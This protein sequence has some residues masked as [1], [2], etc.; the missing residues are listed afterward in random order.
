MKNMYSRGI[1]AT[2][3]MNLCRFSACESEIISSNNV[4]L[5]ITLRSEEGNGSV[6]L[7]N[8]THRNY[9][10]NPTALRTAILENLRFRRKSQNLTSLWSLVTV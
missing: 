6:F 10:I 8:K 9:I 7:G 2:L 1:P 5:N 4:L 3:H